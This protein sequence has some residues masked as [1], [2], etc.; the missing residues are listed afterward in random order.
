M[1][2]WIVILGILALATLASATPLACT[3]SC[4]ITAAS[5]GY[6]TAV[7]EVR[8]GVPLVWHSSDIGHT[9]ADLGLGA[10]CLS[11]PVAGGSDSQPV[12]FTISGGA[13]TATVG[14]NA[15]V[16]CGNAIASPDGSFSLPYFCK[17]HSTMRGELVVSQ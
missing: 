7:F 6:N 9:Q 5:T 12:T 11:V 4:R 14:A 15:P 17:I 2:P 1:R 10:A 16:T 13:L 3:S 8:A